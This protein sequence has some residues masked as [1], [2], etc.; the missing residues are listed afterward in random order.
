MLGEFETD[1]QSRHGKSFLLVKIILKNTHESKTSQP[2][3]TYSHLN[4]PIDQ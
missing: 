3:L 2:R 4:T 1:V